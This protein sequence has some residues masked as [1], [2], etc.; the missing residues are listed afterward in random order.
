MNRLVG[1]ANW[2]WILIGLTVPAAA[3]CPPGIDP[4]IDGEFDWVII[5]AAGNPPYDGPTFN[6][7]PPNHTGSVSR[8]YRI[9]RTE[10][11]AA[12]WLE[13]ANAFGPLGDPFRIGRDAREIEPVIGTQYVFQYAPGEEMH[14]A[15]VSNIQ[16]RNAAR[17]CNWL[18]NGKDVS[19]EALETGAYDTTTFGD[20]ECGDAGLP[21]FTDDPT[22]L[23]GARYWIP[24]LDEWMKAVH[25]DPETGWRLYPD[26]GDEPLVSGS[27]L[28]PQAETNTEYDG[29]DEAYSY[30][31]G[32]YPHVQTPWGL[33]D[34]SG[35]VSEWLENIQPYSGSRPF[36][37]MK[38]GSSR[39]QL[40]G[41]VLDHANRFQSDRADLVTGVTG[42][43]L[44]SRAT[45][46]V[47]ADLTGDGVVDFQDLNCVL[48][49]WGTGVA[50]LSGDG[51]TDFVELTLVI[52]QWGCESE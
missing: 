48:S 3:D 28:D 45:L 30:R 46:D 29:P 15:A 24:T 21:C 25:Y 13:F 5:G 1:R 36:R 49:E 22:H 17:Y 16:W 31:I 50:D 44:A 40:L 14:L 2:L 35:G 34:A 10:I 23:P 18:H 32:R 43:R 9:M 52:E 42:L 37:R 26:G 39:G 20:S 51:Q 47:F 33:L 12:Q 27:A 41:L 8:E 19:L 4:V 7:M 6:L 38:A 11:S